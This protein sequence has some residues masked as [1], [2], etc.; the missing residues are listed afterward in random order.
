MKTN[1]PFN[2]IFLKIIYSTFKSQMKR[3]KNKLC[4][5][6]IKNT[7]LLFSLRKK[8]SNLKLI[9]YKS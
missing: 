4:L 5:K 6:D 9:D 3:F 7:S 8:C 2:I 1:T